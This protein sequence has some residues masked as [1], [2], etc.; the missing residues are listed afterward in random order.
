[1]EYQPPKVEEVEVKELQ[2]CKVCQKIKE[3]SVT[4]KIGDKVGFCHTT[5]SGKGFKVSSV[6]GELFALMRRG[7][8]I[9]AS[10]IRRKKLY[11]VHSDALTTT[12][13]VSSLTASFI[14]ICECKE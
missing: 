10:V 13:G 9:I 6:E 1:M 5:R 3:V 7:D 8:E 2:K 11:S 12:T 4:L 14:G